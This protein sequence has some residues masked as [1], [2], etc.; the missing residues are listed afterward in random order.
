MVFTTMRQRLERG[1]LVCNVH[2]YVEY[3]TVPWAGDRPMNEDHDRTMTTP[4]RSSFTLYLALSC[5]LAMLGFF[6]QPSVSLR[7][8]VWFVLDLSIDRYLDS[9]VRSIIC[10]N[11][12]MAMSLFLDNSGHRASRFGGVM[13]DLDASTGRP[14]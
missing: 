4:K 3:F 9:Y 13:V 8:C 7:Q 14:W 10:Q 5:V 1:S 11:F 12:L 2:A 6:S